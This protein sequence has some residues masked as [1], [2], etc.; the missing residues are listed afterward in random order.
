MLAPL[1]TGE[2]QKAKERKGE[3]RRA[4]ESKGEQKTTNANNKNKTSATTRESKCEHVKA[5]GT[6]QS[7]FLNKKSKNLNRD[8]DDISVAISDI[9][10]THFAIV[11]TAAANFELSDFT[12]AR[13]GG[14]E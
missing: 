9:S 2:Q 11:D 6:G 7:M 14:I 5:Q 12:C 8:V 13:G 1:V 10:I 3:R 4:T